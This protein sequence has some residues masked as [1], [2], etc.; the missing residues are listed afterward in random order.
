MEIVKQIIRKQALVAVARLTK[1]DRR[2]NHGYRPNSIAC[3][4]WPYS[5]A[6]MR[7]PF[8]KQVGEPRARDDIYVD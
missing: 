1:L 6:D 4:S 3:Q 5:E 7:P 8:A 2:S